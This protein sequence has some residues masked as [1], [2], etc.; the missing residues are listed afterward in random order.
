MCVIKY[1]VNQE[2]HDTEISNEV[3]YPWKLEFGILKSYSR[4]RHWA[5]CMFCGCTKGC[6]RHSVPMD[7]SSALSSRRPDISEGLKRLKCRS[8]I[9]IGENSPFHYESLH[10][11]S[12]LDR[13]YTALV[14][15]CTQSYRANLTSRLYVNINTCNMRLY[16]IFMVVRFSIVGP[17]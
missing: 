8:L 15:V 2:L 17:W 14:E 11:T 1:D 13:R 9:F 3:S 7:L 6:T 5:Y 16:L 4:A 10:M 12:K